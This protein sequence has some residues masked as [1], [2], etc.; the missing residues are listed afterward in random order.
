MKTPVRRRCGLMKE[1]PTARD[2]APEFSGFNRKKA[3]PR[4]DFRCPGAAL[5][6]RLREE[7]G[8]LNAYCTF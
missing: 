1:G 6:I 8:F 4:I 5:P 2:E 3:A 7:A